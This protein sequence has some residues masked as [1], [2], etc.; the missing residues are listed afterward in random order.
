MFELCPFDDEQ[1]LLRTNQIQLMAVEDSLEDRRDDFTAGTFGWSGTA[2]GDGGPSNCKKS[3]L[4]SKN[5]HDFDGS[6]GFFG[7]DDPRQKPLRGHTLP[8]EGGDHL[9]CMKSPLSKKSL[10]SGLDSPL[11]T[12][13]VIISRYLKINKIT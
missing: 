9:N 12:L 2:T 4:S 13:S 11:D 8:L 5:S 3:P 7:R 1:H 10:F 6:L